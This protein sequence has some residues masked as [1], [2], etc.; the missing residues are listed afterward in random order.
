MQILKWSSTEI[1]G[2]KKEIDGT[3]GPKKGKWHMC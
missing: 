3:K 2:H 1:R